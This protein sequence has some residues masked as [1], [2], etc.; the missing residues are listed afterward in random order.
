MYEGKKPAKPAKVEK[1]EKGGKASLFDLGKEE[2]GGGCAC[3]PFFLFFWLGDFLCVWEEK[4]CVMSL[5]VWLY[6]IP[7]PIFSS[8]PPSF[9]LILPTHI[10]SPSFSLLLLFPFLWEYIQCTRAF[11]S[12]QAAP[13]SHQPCQS[14]LTVRGPPPLTARRKEEGN[15]IVELPSFLNGNGVG[16]RPHNTQHEWGS[17]FHGD[18]EKFPKSD[19]ARKRF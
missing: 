7:D 15:K 14:R 5:A 18:K 2:G 6:L 12:R 3:L 4:G 9:F 16:R 19:R 10:V 8:L 1:G 11:R 13:V 17:S